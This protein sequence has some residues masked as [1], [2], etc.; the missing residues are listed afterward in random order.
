MNVRANEL[1][2]GTIEAGA[3][4]LHLNPGRPPVV[5]V[6]GALVALGSDVLDDKATRELCREV[7]RHRPRLWP[8][9]KQRLLKGS[10]RMDA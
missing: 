5:R 4:D 7:D 6:N 10:S 9:I 3:S 1:M 8:L 2:T